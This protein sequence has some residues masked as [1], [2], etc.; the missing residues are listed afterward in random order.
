MNDAEFDIWQQRV[1][2][3]GDRSDLDCQSAGW[4]KSLI[5][6]KEKHDAV[7]VC[8]VRCLWD[9]GRAVSQCLF[10]MMRLARC[11]SREETL[12]VPFREKMTLG[13]KQDSVFF[14]EAALVPCLMLE[15][16]LP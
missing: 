6:P 2:A 9:E 1:R 4:M 16:I 10:V 11:C 15:Q 5:S 8:H 12:S 14:S 7:F 3:R 13:K